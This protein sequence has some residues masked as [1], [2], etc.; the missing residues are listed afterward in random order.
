M[1]LSA[2]IVQAVLPWAATSFPIPP[3]DCHWAW[4]GEK[5]IAKMNARKN[6]TGFMHFPPR[7]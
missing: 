3:K 4:A 2:P 5:L 7:S 1:P 6:S